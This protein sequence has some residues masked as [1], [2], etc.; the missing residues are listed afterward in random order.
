MIAEA[1]GSPYPR[2]VEAAACCRPGDVGGPWFY[3]ERLDALPVPKH[4]SHADL[5]AWF[6]DD[7]DPNA[8][9]AEGLTDRVAARARGSSYKTSSK[10]PRRS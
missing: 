1:K 4:K 10:R 2:L 8:V 5:K 9:D 7:F 6:V 3:A